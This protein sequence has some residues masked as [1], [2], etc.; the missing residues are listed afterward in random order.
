MGLGGPNLVK[1]AIGQ[2]TDAES[3]GGESMHTRTSGVAHYSAKDDA[4]C[5]AIIRRL[6]RELPAAPAQAAR[7]EGPAK[8][9]EDLY[10]LMPDDHRAAVRHE[11]SARAHCGCRRVPGISTRPRA[12]VPVRECADLRAIRLPSS[13]TGADF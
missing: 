11:R 9:A 3:L 7:I 5:L 4:D 1:G 12:G 2:A 13:R 8:P 6:F 10:E